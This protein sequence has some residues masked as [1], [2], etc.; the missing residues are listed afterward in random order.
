MLPKDGRTVLLY[1]FATSLAGDNKE[2][3]MGA[4]L[5]D[6]DVCLVVDQHAGLYFSASSLNQQSTDRHGAP[7]E[8]LIPKRSHQSFV[9]YCLWRMPIREATINNCIVFGLTRLLLEPTFCRIPGEHTY[10]YATEVVTNK[11]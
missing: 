5:T 8:Q 3:T 1:L 4:S 2:G 7:L 6:S 10:H 9:L 11:S